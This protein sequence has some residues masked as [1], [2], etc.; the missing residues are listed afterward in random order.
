MDKTEKKLNAIQSGV[1]TIKNDVLYIKGMIFELI[2]QIKRKNTATYESG[3][4]S[5]FTMPPVK[6]DSEMF[7]DKKPEEII[8]I[9]K[10]AVGVIKDLKE[11]NK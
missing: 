4:P 7:K 11:L 10:D 8:N 1:N 3:P 6:I 5:P 9:M 2:N